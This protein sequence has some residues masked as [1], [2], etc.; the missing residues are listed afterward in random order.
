[1]NRADLIIYGT[2]VTLTILVILLA[3]FGIRSTQQADSVNR[4]L[5]VDVLHCLAGTRL[6]NKLFVWGIWEGQLSIK[7]MRLILHDAEGALLT[8]IVF[9]HFPIDGVLQAFTLDGC[10]YECVNKDLL[11]G[12]SWLRDAQS[13][14]IVLSCQHGVRYNAFYRATSDDELFKVKH[15]SVFKGYSVIMRNN[16]ENGR[17]FNLQHPDCFVPVLTLGTP[18]LSRLEQCFIFVSL[19]GKA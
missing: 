5:T 8:E 7:E 9:F 15:G 19:P 2:L 16:S 3:R 13:G 6:Q 4:Q 12:R 14:E 1:M 11:S 18:A 10:G 17:L